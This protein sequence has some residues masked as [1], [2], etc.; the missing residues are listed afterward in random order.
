MRITYIAIGDEI[1]HGETR[2]GNG[3]FFAETLGALGL[4]LDEMRVVG[5]EASST[6]KAVQELAAEPSLIVTSGGIGPTDDDGTREAVS[7]AAGVPLEVNEEVAAVLAE[8]Y[9]RLGRP[10]HDANRRQAGIPRGADILE[11]PFGTAPGF[12]VEVGRSV[13]AVMPGVPREF[14]AMLGAFLPGLLQRCGVAFEER[15]EVTL[16]VFGTTEAELQGILGDLPGYDGVH[17]RSLPPR[18]RVATPELTATQ[19]A[20]P[21][22]GGSSARTRRSASR[23]RC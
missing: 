23:R 11:N 8:R 22:A 13:V 9:A 18:A 14:R 6:I 10:H 15:E 20:R 12:A 3:A 17:V 1:L 7:R 2:E 4:N 21:S 19:P 5:D 16:R